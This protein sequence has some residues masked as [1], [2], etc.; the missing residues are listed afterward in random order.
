MDR[1]EGFTEF[2]AA[3]G[4]SLSRTAYLLTGDH[5]RAEELLQSALVRTAPHWRRAGVF[6]K[7]P[8]EG[9]VSRPREEP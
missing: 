1:Y 7:M 3:R 9:R 2:I 4:A 8:G 6:A 5:H